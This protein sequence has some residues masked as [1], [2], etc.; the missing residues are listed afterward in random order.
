MNKVMAVYTVF[1]RVE[2][3]RFG[4]ETLGKRVAAG[5]R[6]VRRRKP[7]IGLKY[8]TPEHVDFTS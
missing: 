8:N 6:M 3:R 4:W 1:S 2:I 5:A 7:I